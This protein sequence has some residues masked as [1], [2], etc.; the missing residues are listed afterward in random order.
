MTITI[1]SPT[2]VDLA[3]GTLDMWPL[4]NF[5]GGATTINVAIDIWTE[6]Q[7]SSTTNG[8]IEIESKDLKQVWKFADNTSFLTALDPKILFFQKIVEK[9]KLKTGFRLVTSSQSPMGG[10]LGGSS[11]L[12]IS[13]LKAFYTLTATK[14][15]T[16]DLVQ[17]AHNIESEILR[18]PTGTQDY[19]PAV[20]GGMS[21]I[22]Y[23]ANSILQTQHS[24][25]GTPLE[26]HFLLVYTG[27]SHHSGL[28]NFEVL[29]SAVEG[30]FKVISA[31]K[32]IKEIAEN[33][34]SALLQKDWD[35]I[36]GLFRQEYEARI[37]LT[38]AF[39]SPEIE[40]LAKISIAAGALA[41][42]ICG[43]G[44]GGCVLIWVPPAQREKVVQVCQNE[45][46]QCL[47]ARP[48]NPLNH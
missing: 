5:V 25:E 15:N 4:Y 35:L 45:K 21:F 22:D 46:F 32:K 23:S 17:L 12:V 40:K 24:V 16:Q 1:K 44:G 20:T 11:S 14:F 29:K 33:L 18:T 10:G 3:G 28:N 19:Y 43:A 38:P 8:S 13:I 26:D 39:S 30:D 48:V 47:S 36:P 34:K 9:F 2:R 31:L 41:V 27:K 6:A 42:K 7:L 37:E